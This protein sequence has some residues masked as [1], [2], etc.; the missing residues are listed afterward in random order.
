M[1]ENRESIAD[2][3][4]TAVPQSLADFYARK[5]RSSNVG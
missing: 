5:N 1:Y 4:M 2:K 3:A